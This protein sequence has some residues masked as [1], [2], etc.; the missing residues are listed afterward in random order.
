MR[1]DKTDEAD[2]ADEGNGNCR[3][4]ANQQHGLQPKRA[5]IDAEGRCLIVTQTERRQGPGAAGKERHAED[6]HGE[7]DCHLAPCRLGQRSHGPE[8]D[9]GKRLFR[10]EIL[11][12]RQQRVEGEDQ[13]DAE[14]H[15]RFDRDATHGRD[16]IDEQ[17]GEHRH[18]EGVDRDHVLH[19][20]RKDGNTGNEAECGAETGRCGNAEREGGGERIGK[21]RLHLSARK[22]QTRA[23][24]YG[25]Q[26]DRHADIPDDDPQLIAG[27][28][29]VP[30]RRDDFG[31]RV[32]CRAVSHVDRNRQHQTE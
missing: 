1:A 25:H 30:D 23:Y 24:R 8:H 12:Q 18:Q 4:Q 10:G 7:G 13:C 28:G 14:Q 31:Q 16:A 3:K 21:D 9:G 26:R 19:G 5:H 29:G 32:A 15:D 17:R 20:G 2:G 27:R 22:R 11:E 6:E